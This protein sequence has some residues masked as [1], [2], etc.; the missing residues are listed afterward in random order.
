MTRRRSV[1]Q[2]L[3][4]QLFDLLQANLQETGDW[5]ASGASCE[6]AVA[7]LAPAIKNLVAVVKELEG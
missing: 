4:L 2:P 7:V 6:V 5:P 3:E 1:P